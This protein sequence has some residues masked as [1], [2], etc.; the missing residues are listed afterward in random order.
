M[1]L[2]KST[3]FPRSSARLGAR[4]STHPSPAYSDSTCSPSAFSHS[5]R[6]SPYL[7]TPSQTAFPSSSPPVSTSPLTQTLQP[8]SLPA[9]TSPTTPQAP[10]A[11]PSCK[12]QP[13]SQTGTSHPQ[14]FA[15]QTN[16]GRPVSCAQYTESQAHIA[17]PSPTT[18]RPASNTIAHHYL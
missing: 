11:T 2:F 18:R 14:N 7:P 16:C 4:L 15:P 17:L 13:T 3:M 1:H 9:R 12:K 6:S 8:T 5:R 10:T